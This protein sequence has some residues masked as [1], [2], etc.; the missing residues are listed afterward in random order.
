MAEFRAAPHETKTRRRLAIAPLGDL[1]S[2]VPIAKGLRFDIANALR[3]KGTP[4]MSGD[5]R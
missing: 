1:S 3:S 5:V 2:E 4:F